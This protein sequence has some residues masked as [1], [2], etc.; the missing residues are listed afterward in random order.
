MFDLE[1]SIADWRKQMLA[2]GIKT[3]VPL[4]EL[5]IHLREEIE[6]Q[7]Q[8]GLNAEK[9]FASGVQTIG[10]VCALKTEF[11]KVG[12]VEK[13]AKWERRIAGFILVGAVIPPATFAL[14]K[15]EMSLAWRLLGFADVAVIILA[16]LGGRYI[17]RS[18]PVVLDKRVR[19]VIGIAFGLLSMTGMVV[20]MNFVL[21]NFELTEGQLVVVVL[22]ALTLTAALGAVW[23][24][25]E[26]AARRQNAS[27]VS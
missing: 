9:A 13:S 11:A 26:E 22:W 15:N 3:P 17:N 14:L 27:A 23:A 20:F 2:A 10:Q 4:E 16:V 5:E 7:T 6:R 19:M 25:L 21:P 1:K 24:G 18:F 12:G 8:S